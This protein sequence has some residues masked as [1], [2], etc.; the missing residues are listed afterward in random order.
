MACG[1]SS[2][3]EFIALLCFFLTQSNESH[4]LINPPMDQDAVR[5]GLI[6]EGDANCGNKRLDKSVDG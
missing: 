5:R 3:G 4:Q 1:E 2:A 6:T